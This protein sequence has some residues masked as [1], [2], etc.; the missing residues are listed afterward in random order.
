MAD[1]WKGFAQTFNPQQ[2][3]QPLIDQAGEDRRWKKLQEQRA[4]DQQDA[5][6]LEAYKQGLKQQKELADQ[7]N[8]EDYLKWATE[9]NDVVNNTEPP[10]E[11]APTKE[12]ELARLTSD[13]EKA[14]WD[15]IYLSLP[16]DKRVALDKRIEEKTGG[17][18]R[19]VQGIDHAFKILPNGEVLF[20]ET[21]ASLQKKYETEVVDRYQR[22]NPD[23]PSLTDRVIVRANGEEEVVATFKPPKS[24]S[25]KEGKVSPLAT[26]DGLASFNATSNKKITGTLEKRQDYL[27]LSRLSG[28]SKAKMQK[29]D[30]LKSQIDAEYEIVHTSILEDATPEQKANILPSAQLLQLHYKHNV[31]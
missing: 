23:N 10:V 15:A 2:I 5:M 6:D 13:E 16:S 3:V 27:R 22:Q 30:K 21:I 4:L 31:Q 8:A 9:T 17:S 18:W 7:K 29:L 26:N 28:N 12:Q 20:S 25:S 1:F 11:G 19:V 24:Q 14:K